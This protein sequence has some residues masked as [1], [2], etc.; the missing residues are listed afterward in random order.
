MRD[1][2][3]QVHGVTNKIHRMTDLY[4]ENTE[5]K[6]QVKRLERK[7]KA[8]WDSL[9]KAN[10]KIK[11]YKL[12]LDHLDNPISEF[13][14]DEIA[15]AVS[16]ASQTTL[17]EMKGRSRIRECV[18]ARQVFFYIGRRAGFSWKKLGQYLLRDHSTAIHGYNQM[19]YYVAM[20]KM[21][22]SESQIYLH[23]REILGSR[24]AERYNAI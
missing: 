24:N 7:C 17:K 5:L 18:I 14:L 12:V 2:R 1:N 10:E 8:L 16:T 6:I 9:Q 4:K 19:S 11:E 3:C 13:P 21:N 20:P 23:T 22:K 15:M